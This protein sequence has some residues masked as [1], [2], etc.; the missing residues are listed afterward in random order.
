MAQKSKF[1]DVVSRLKED[2]ILTDKQ[3][4]YLDEKLKEK[5]KWAKCENLSVFVIGV[6]TTSQIESMHSVLR[7]EL[8]SNSRLREVLHVFKE[9]EKT[10]TTK[11]QQ[12][13]TRHKKNLNKDLITSP[14]IELLENI[15]T[16]YIIKK[17]E[18]II[19]KSINHKIEKKSE[20]SW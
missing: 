4:E 15:Y 2:D 17:L 9:I 8:N 6:S 7:E 18:Q 5:E 11:F 13:F 19:S 3:L 14:L 12:E 20:N 16:P 1:D 10:E